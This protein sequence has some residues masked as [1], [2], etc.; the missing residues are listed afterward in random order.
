MKKL[1]LAIFLIPTVGFSQTLNGIAIEDLDAKYIEIVGTSKLLKPFQVNITVNYGQV[2][3]VSE[4]S[5]AKVLGENGK[6]YPFNGMMG[7]VNFFS[8]RGYKLDMAYPLTVG[9]SNVYHYIMLKE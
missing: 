7:V 6:P 8:D 2:G 4:L 3:R 9:N 1:I 5:K